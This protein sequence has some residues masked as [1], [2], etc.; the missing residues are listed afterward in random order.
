MSEEKI[1][2]VVAEE[3]DRS[4]CQ[5]CNKTMSSKNFYLMPDG[6]RCNMCK[7]CLT[8]HIDNWDPETYL[9][10]MEKFDVP[11]VD[12]EWTILRDRAYNKNPAK[13]N[14]MSVFGRYLSKMKLKQWKNYGWLDSAE[15]EKKS[16]EDREKNSKKSDKEIQDELTAVKLAYANGEITEAQYL[17]YKESQKEDNSQQLTKPTSNLPANNGSAAQGL[18]TAIAENYEDM[19]VDI[20]ADL[21]RQ[22]KIY[23]TMKWGQFYHPNE[24]VQLEKFYT[25]MEESFDIQGAGRIDTLKIICK[26]SLKLNQAIDCG[27]IDTFQKLSRVYDSLMKSAKF[28]EAQNKEEKGNFVDCVGDLVTLCEKEGFIPR[29]ATNIPQDKVD[30]TLKD[31]NNYVYKLVSQDLGFGKQIENQLKKIKIQ[32]EQELE[33]AELEA[34]G[35]ETILKDS[36][37]TDYYE[38]E[39]EEVKEDKKTRGEK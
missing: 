26:T 22:D 37:V 10:L 39:E 30:K 9:W 28:T 8:M 17:T 24:W 14:G 21:T 15:L 36:D 18:M 12:A 11:Y 2:R 35:L 27:D 1:T 33:E 6:T 31:M 19:G 3:K 20:G 34:S 16:K 38:Q 25:E 32:R 5:K 7:P 4:Y 13:M 23:L 29:Y